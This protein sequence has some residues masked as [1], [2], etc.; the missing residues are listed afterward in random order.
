MLRGIRASCL[1]LLFLAA[2]SSN[3]SGA[4]PAATPQLRIADVQV[5]EGNS[6]TRVLG[7]TVTLDRAASGDVSVDYA[8]AGGSATQG[9]DFQAAS[10]RLTI[11]AGQT[12][13]SIGVNVI[14]DTAVEG[15]ETLTITLS[16]ASGAAIADASATGTIVDDDSAP[17]RTLSIA[18]A[19]LGEG[20]SGTRAMSFTVSLDQAASTDV[21]V[22]Y[23]TASGSATQGVDFQSASGRITVPAGQTQ[24]SIAVNLIGDT[25]TE[26]NET[27]LVTLAAPAGAVIG[28][29]SAIGTILDDDA[30]SGS[31]LNIADAQ[32]TEGNSGTSAMSF[33]VSL[34]RASSSDISVDYATSAGSATPGADFQSANGRITIPAGQTQASVSVN[35]IGDTAPE[36]SET[37]TV[38]LANSGGVNIA[39]GTATGTIVDDDP[40][41][42]SLS[43]TGSAI[44]EPDAGTAPLTF[45]VTLSGSDTRTV[46]VAYATANGTATAGSDYASTSGTLTFAPGQTQKTVSVAVSGDTIAEPDESFTLNLSNPVNATLANASAVGT[47]RDNDGVRNL[48]VDG[49]AAA[50]NAGSMTFTVHLDAASARTVTVNYA[51]FDGTAIAPGDYTATSGTLSFAPGETSKTFSVALVND[52]TQESTETFEVRLSGAVN[53]NIADATDTGTITDDDMPPP[54][55]SLDLDVLPDM[56]TADRC[57]FLDNHYCLF[58]W[59]NDYFTAPQPVSANAYGSSNALHLNLNI[60]SM[61]RNVAGKPLDPTEWNRNDGFSPG[62]A[63]LVRVPG[64]DIAASNAVPITDVGA[65][66]RGDQPVVVIDATTLQRHPVWTEIDADITK[67]GPCDTVKP[68]E[69]LGAI[70]DQQD[71]AAAAASLRA[72]C[73]ASPLPPDPTVNN[74]PA[75]IIR[76][77]KNFI[78]GHRYIVALRN[79]KTAGGV[80]LAAPA[81]FRIYRDKVPSMLPMVN[82]RRAHMEEVLSTLAGSGIARGSLYLAWDFT[83]ASQRNLSE[84]LLHIR[85]DAFTRLGASAPSFTIRNVDTACTIPGN[86]SCPAHMGVVDHVGADNIAREVYGTITV[87]SYLNIP[88]GPAGSRFF[89]TPG[90]EGQY[91]DGLPDVNPVQPTQTFSFLCRIPRTAFGGAENPATAPTAV[92]ARPAIYGHGLLGSMYEGGGQIGDMISENNFVY[93]ATDWIGMSGHQLDPASLQLADPIYRDP[94]G[95]DVPNVASILVDMSNFPTLADRVQQGVIDFHYLARALIHAGGFCSNAAFQA[96]DGSCVIDRSEVFYDGNSQGGII[97]GVVLATSPDIKAGVLGV[98]GMNYSTLLQRSVDFDQYAAFMYASYRNSLDQQFVLSFIQDLW[99]R[100]ENDGY[101]QHLTPATAYANTPGKRVLLHPSFGDHQVSMYTA[102]VM[103]R[104]VGAGVHCPAVVAGTDPQRGPAVLPGPHPLVGNDPLDHDRR[105]PDDEPYFGIPCIAAYPFSGNALAVWDSGPTKN[106]DGSTRPD[107]VAP[108]P[109]DNTPPRPS[110]GYGA[111]PHSFPRTTFEAR[112]QKAEFLKSGGAVIDTCGGE[113]CVTRGFDPTP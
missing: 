75:V 6:G 16:G 74:G 56:L 55:A 78:E 57:D 69:A 109:T 82:A 111:D 12:Q 30:T 29:A 67:F 106:P 98:P 94:P 47:I 8:S 27:F 83:V 36:G 80:T 86:P 31:S 19:Q 18:D 96:A 110:L 34:S 84:R 63:I 13:S 14:G 97:G 4:P 48:G 42:Q 85:D 21:S 105:H 68:A 66:S 15:N 104:T 32:L 2:C 25:A 59:P 77:A 49:A 54:P 70:V 87:P 99:D 26:T 33:V 62:Q 71:L 50:E 10:G 28:D 7:F 41:P 92:A 112:R 44:D 5:T 102:E 1:S 46:T 38:T 43:I 53:A 90:A 9:S 37:F 89:Y 23:S 88:G 61:P 107:G 35:V 51:T 40:V 113:P 65:Y 72:Q 81:A 95:G 39:D 101:A 93:C 52:S 24:A 100:A 64:F 3:E 11:P 91:G 108:P 60:L 76:P 79:L 45:T 22:A 73:A 103:A 17:V 58:P 20:D